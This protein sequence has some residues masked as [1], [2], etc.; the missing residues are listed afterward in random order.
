MTPYL[1]KFEGEADA[2]GKTFTFKSKGFDPMTNK[3]AEHKMVWE[4]KDQDHR[5]MKFYGKDDTG[6]EVLLS[7]CTYTRKPAMVK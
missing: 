3:E 1:Y 4:V 7:E 6:K 2:G 5:T